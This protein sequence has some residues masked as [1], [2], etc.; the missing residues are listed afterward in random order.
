MEIRVTEVFALIDEL[1]QYKTEQ[2]ILVQSI[3]KRRQEFEEQLA[4]EHRLRTKEFRQIA[5]QEVRKDFSSCMR[6]FS[7][8]AIDYGRSY[9]ALRRHVKFKNDQIWNKY[10]LGKIKSK[11]PRTMSTLFCHS[12][13][14]GDM[15]L[16]IDRFIDKL[17]IA[18]RYGVQSIVLSNDEIEFL[19]K[20]ENKFS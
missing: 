12:S 6:Y 20:C 3:E 17:I 2:Q 1:E 14:A 15:L 13:A 18:Q 7:S 9:S 16:E 4:I 10:L 19:A 11:I 5:I 8:Y